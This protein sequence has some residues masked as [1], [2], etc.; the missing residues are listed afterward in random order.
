MATM[1]LYRLI[2]LL[3]LNCRK[4][5]TVGALCANPTAVDALERDLKADPLVQQE[6]RRTLRPVTLV[7]RLACSERSPAAIEDSLISGA[8]ETAAEDSE[9]LLALEM[10]E[11]QAAGCHSDAEPPTKR[12]TVMTDFSAYDRERGG[13]AILAAIIRLFVHVRGRDTV[14]SIMARRDVYSKEASSVSLRGSIAVVTK[15][16][17]EHVK[18]LAA[19]AKAQSDAIPAAMPTQ[20]LPDHDPDRVAH[21]AEADGVDEDGEVPLEYLESIDRA[22]AEAGEDDVVALLKAGGD[23]YPVPDS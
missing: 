7:G 8:Q 12:R 10:A 17:N 15:R 16:L 20:S 22:L 14:R 19:K 9:L 18:K 5:L 4:R 11:R 1:P 6:F 23:L 3:E 2:T 21:H 13:P